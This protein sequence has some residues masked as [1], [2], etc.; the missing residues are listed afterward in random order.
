MKKLFHI[1]DEEG[2]DG[3]GDG[4]GSDREEEHAGGSGESQSQGHGVES[5]LGALQQVEEPEEILAEAALEEATFKP[6]TGRETEVERLRA[7]TRRYHAL[8]ELLSTEVGYL[9]DLRALVS[10]YLE[11]LHTLS[12]TAPPHPSSA[13][14]IPALG[15]SRSI[16]SSRSSFLHP[17]S[18]LPSPSASAASHLGSDP[19]HGPPDEKDREAEREKTRSRS[20]W[21]G[22]T[23]LEADVHDHRKS[24]TDERP[25]SPAQHAKSKH[26]RRA[27]LAEKDVREVCRNAD[28]LLRFHERFVEELREVVSPTGFGAAFVPGRREEAA[29]AEDAEVMATERIDEAVGAVAE[30]FVSQAPS[31]GIYET[32]CPGHSEAANLIRSVQENYPVEWDA[33]EQRCSLLIAHTF[34][35]V[36]RPTS[37]AAPSAFRGPAVHDE[38]LPPTPTSASA[39]PPPPFLGRKKRRHST[40]SISIPE[41]IS[42]VGFLPTTTSY[43][44]VVVAAQTEPSPRKRQGSG[45]AASVA[46]KGQSQAT[47]LKF[48]DYLI[49]PVQRICKYPLLLDQ[50][51]RSRVRV[52]SDTTEHEG[53]MAVEEAMDVVESASEAMRLVVSLV[54]RASETQAHN[55]KS[56]LIAS[57]MASAPSPPGSIGHGSTPSSRPISPHAGS[58]GLTPDFIASLGPCHLVG[59]LD[60]VRHPSPLYAPSGG[61]LRAKYLGAF[62]YMG[63]YLVLAKVTKG[64]RVYEPRYWFSLVGFD[65]A[66]ACQPEKMI[67]MTAIQDVLTVPQSWTNEPLS[68]LQ[69]DEGQP[70]S[71]LD[72]DTVEGHLPTIQSL[73]ELETQ[74]ERPAT[75][76]STPTKAR[77]DM[78]PVKSHR[79]D[80]M[81]LR[82][83]QQ[84]QVTSL[85]A[86]NR[87]SSTASVKAFFSP[88]SLDA[89]RITRPSM[90]MR[91]QIDQNLHDVFSENCINVR[92]TAQRRD[93]ELFHAR[94][95]SGS[96]M[97]RSNSGLSITGAM[98]LAAKRRYDSVL[99]SRR[100]SSVGGG[101]IHGESLATLGRGK[102]LA[103]KRRKK[104]L[105]SVVPTVTSNLTKVE[106]EAELELPAT[107]SPVEGLDSPF[108]LSQCSSTTSSNA[109]SALPSPVALGM[110]LPVPDLANDAT[111]R[112]SDVLM[113]H[114]ED[115]RP[116]R[117]R[118]M[119][120]NVRYFFQSRP[121]SPSSSS[122][123]SPPTPPLMPLVPQYPPEIEPPVSIVQWWRKGSLRRR[124]QS[125]PDVPGEEPQPIPAGRSSEDTRGSFLVSRRPVTVPEQP[126]NATYGPPDSE[127]SQA[128]SRRVAFTGTM[129]SRRR[130][131][132]VPSTIH[133][134]ASPQPAASGPS[135][136]NPRRSLK[137]VLFFQ[138]SNSFTP[139]DV[140]SRP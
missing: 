129:P 139:M 136:F 127:S 45:A 21:A 61:T 27:L 106:S 122:D 100:K 20:S 89:A 76:P 110:S 111:I 109:G 79:L 13:L 28:E 67:W 26:V 116:K 23:K 82:Q 140:K 64:G 85:A 53:D 41:V 69:V 33:Y 68:S 123:H 138:R 114:N 97:S 91:Q 70:A 66:A 83:E 8:M 135:S 39:V 12:T 65:L 115:Y 40:S 15:L 46:H 74:G 56:L 35:L 6:E 22:P 5:V 17:S 51:R 92:S 14:S 102:S 128:S 133:R 94:K 9:M 88:M 124:V 2:I 18:P 31:F 113:A 50:L 80:S 29:D 103:S 99:V 71:A 42:P 132:L 73:S 55:V 38:S 7:G 48:L 77:P 36:A 11:Q 59:A 54:D 72:D 119:V 37:T 131:L 75:E 101:E 52:P 126:P 107:Q 47:R 121:A 43:M 3:D 134:D 58:Q 117:T 57:R 86:L 120:D 84:M 4:D 137:N 112:Q 105:P 49:K 62:L 108:P 96:G 60:V 78:K 93:E 87:R 44:G 34:G 81:A 24:A 10:V 95:R 118:S 90:Q 63:G 98:G 1:D 25:S 19:G 104:T 32:F 16:P 30:K 125:S 130:S